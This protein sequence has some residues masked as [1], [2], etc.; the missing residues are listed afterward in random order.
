MPD[1]L[2][3]SER[4]CCPAPSALTP[5]TIR[6]SDS[7][8]LSKNILMAKP[9]Q[10]ATPAKTALITGITGQ[11]GA[12]RDALVKSQGYKIADPRE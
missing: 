5:A 1:M 10:T 8:P 6:C 11:D 9:T 7:A 2:R 4:G 3:F 12:H